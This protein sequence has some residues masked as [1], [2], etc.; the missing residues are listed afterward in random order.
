MSNRF[1]IGFNDYVPED[2]PRI[3]GKNAGLGEMIK[4][5]LPVPPGFAITTD[6]FETIRNHPRAVEEV[7]ARL[8]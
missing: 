5:D 4:A 1:I 2:R 8:G 3:G 7:R 6:A